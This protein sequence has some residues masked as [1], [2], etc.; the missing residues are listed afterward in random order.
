MGVVE[1]YYPKAHA[2]VVRIDQ[3]ELHLGDTIH[4]QGRHEDITEPVRSI[5]LDHR[6]IREAHAG[7]KVGVQLS[8]PVHE[9]SRVFLVRGEA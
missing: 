7:D 5:Q 8:Y 2:A 3:G 9:H 6:P 1:H 4:I